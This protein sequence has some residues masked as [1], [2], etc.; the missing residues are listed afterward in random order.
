M[1]HMNY[2]IT[3]INTK[4]GAIVKGSSASIFINNS[5]NFKIRPDLSI[6]N[7]DIE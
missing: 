1:P 7:K 3:Q 2:Q 4:Y 5:L 6:T